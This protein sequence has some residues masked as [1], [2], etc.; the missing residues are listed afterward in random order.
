MSK[1]NTDKFPV[2]P[3]L[4]TRQQAA[5]YC[6][7]SVPTFDGIC[8]VKAIAL[9]NGKRLERFDRISLDGW[10]DSLAQNGREMRKDWLAELEKQ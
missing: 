3:R 7:V 9:G 5:A 8:P 2:I 1:S 10:I 6:G 4:L